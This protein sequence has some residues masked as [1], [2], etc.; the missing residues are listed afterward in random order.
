[1][2]KPPRTVPDGCVSDLVLDE[3]KAGELEAGRAAEVARHLAMCPRCARRNAEIDAATASF[4]EAA[5]VFAAP[6]ASVPE[7]GAAVP[8]PLSPA[9]RS[10]RLARIAGAGAASL[11][12]AAA[13]ALMFRNAPDVATRTKGAAAHVRFFVKHGDAV[14][15][16]GSDDRLHA[17]DQVR[18]VATTDRPRYVA[19]LSL[20]GEGRA[21]V[22]YPSNG[23]PA[24][25]AEGHD[26]ALEGGIELDDALGEERIYA[27]FCEGPIDVERAR[28]SLAA[29]RV[30]APEKGCIVDTLHWTKDP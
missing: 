18:F 19:I 30:I 12:F 5:P 13:V 24:L 4:L 1:M 17:R 23:A 25:L 3:W 8:E 22:Y 6:L 26:V 20:D 28:A 9:R 29:S 21:S 10:S 14:Y 7:A 2:L 27:L 15:Q 16:G 11:A